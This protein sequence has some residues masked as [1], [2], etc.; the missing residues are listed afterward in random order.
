[1]HGFEQLDEGGLAVACRDVALAEAGHDLAEQSDF[2]YAARNQFV[3]L[4]DDAFNRPAALLAACVR[5]DA[6]S[7]ILVASLHD[8]DKRADGFFGT[9][10]EQMF[11]DSRL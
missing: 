7:A 10:V 8:A 11:A 6:K 2:L 9:A 5:H 3:A 4:R 1:M